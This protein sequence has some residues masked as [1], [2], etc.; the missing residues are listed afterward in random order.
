[1]TV[2]LRRSSLCMVPISR[3]AKTKVV[4]LRLCL[5]INRF[6]FDRYAA[7]LYQLCSTV[8][9]FCATCRFSNKCTDVET[10]ISKCFLELRPRLPLFNVSPRHTVIVDICLQASPTSFGDC[11]CLIAFRSCLKVF[12]LHV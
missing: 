11:N 8:S 9:H 6:I 12:E 5:S 2:V 3:E 10:V 4:S 1:M 7:E